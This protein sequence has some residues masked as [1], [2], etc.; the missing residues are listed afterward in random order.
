MVVDR[1]GKAE[2][3]RQY[4]EWNRAIRDT[5]LQ[6]EYHQYSTEE[7]LAALQAELE[8]YRAERKAAWERYEKAVIIE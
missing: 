5:K 2:L 4:N 1:R 6:I 8:E 3:R 7:E